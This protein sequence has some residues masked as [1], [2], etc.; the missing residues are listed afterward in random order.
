MRLYSCIR[1]IHNIAHIL[2]VL[3]NIFGVQYIF[4]INPQFLKYSH[5]LCLDFLNFRISNCKFNEPSLTRNG[6][7]VVVIVR[8]N[9]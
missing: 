1:K 8:P 9:E 2:Y 5:L 4:N 6:A 3:S 7:I